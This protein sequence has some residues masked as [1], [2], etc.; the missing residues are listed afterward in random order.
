[1]HQD[2]LLVDADKQMG[3]ASGSKALIHSLGPGLPRSESCSFP[4]A[5]SLSSPHGPPDNFQSSPGKDQGLGKR[6]AF[7]SVP[8]VCPPQQATGAEEQRGNRV[9]EMPTGL[10]SGAQTPDQQALN[11][12]AHVAAVSQSTCEQ[13][14]SCR[15]PRH[16]HPG[17]DFRPGPTGTPTGPHAGPHTGPIA[18]QLPLAPHLPPPRRWPPLRGA[19]P[20]RA[21]G[22]P[23]IGHKGAWGQGPGGR[24]LQTSET[25]AGALR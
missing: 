21:R 17:T 12:R 25:P 5:S 6:R 24:G 2:R 23:G 9:Q 22:I 16:A 18:Y 14:G 7:C 13:L 8:Q 19:L 1:M 3:T 4:I 10:G 11:L 20:L 15:R